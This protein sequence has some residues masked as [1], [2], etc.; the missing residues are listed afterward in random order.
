MNYKPF[1]KK[2]FIRLLKQA[3]MFHPMQAKGMECKRL[4]SFV[5]LENTDQ[6]RQD[7]F[8]I[9]SNE[10]KYFFSRKGKAE[11]QYPALFIW[12]QNFTIENRFSTDRN[13]RKECSTFE[14]MVLDSKVEDCKNC[15]P[16]Q[17]RSVHDIQCDATEL[18]NNALDYLCT[19]VCALIDGQEEPIWASSVILDQMIVKEEITGY[20]V[21]G[22]RTRSLQ[23]S[24]D[25]STGTIQGGNYR[26]YTKKNLYGSYQFLKICFT[27]CK[28]CDFLWEDKGFKEEV[29][30]CC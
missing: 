18:L 29:L 4:N 3:V 21:D 14:I 5:W 19:V 24:F 7:N 26:S 23:K 27:H 12:E 11:I 25:A 10:S 15:S 2:D 20:T 28:P 22:S 17:K 13:P 8:G 9:T 30:Q 6:I 16:C 1:T